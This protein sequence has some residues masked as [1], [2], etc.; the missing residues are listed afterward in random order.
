MTTEQLNEQS[1][2]DAGRPGMIDT[3]IKLGAATTNLAIDQVGNALTALTQPGVAIDHVKDT[4]LNISDA[5]NNS[6][7]SRVEDRQTSDLRGAPTGMEY[8]AVDVPYERTETREPVQTPFVDVRPPSPH[9]AVRTRV[10]KKI[11]HRKS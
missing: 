9:P 1:S 10:V 3:I 5:M 7:S 8:L 6:A 2:V 4:L 11:N